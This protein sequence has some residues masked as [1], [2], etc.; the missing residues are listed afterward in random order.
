MGGVGDGRVAAKENVERM[1]AD[2]FGLAV[3]RDMVPRGKVISMA[4]AE[5][6]IAPAVQRAAADSRGLPAF[7][8][9]FEQG[10]N[11]ITFLIVE[12]DD[13]PGRVKLRRPG[14]HAP[15]LWQ[16]DSGDT[17]GDVI[18]VLRASHGEPA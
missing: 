7:L 12:G 8:A 3:M 4:A 11:A 1:L 15:P 17:L 14:D 18:R 13:E 10:R 16:V 2:P 6:P 9:V 5:E